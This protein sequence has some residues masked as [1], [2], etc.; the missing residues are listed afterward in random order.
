MASSWV[1]RCIG[2]PAALALRTAEG[3]KKV[4]RA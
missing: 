4:G 1:I 2:T 3:L